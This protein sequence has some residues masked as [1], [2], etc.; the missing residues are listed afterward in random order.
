M[1]FNSFKNCSVVRESAGIRAVPAR[2]AGTARIPVLSPKDFRVMTL[3]VIGHVTIRP[4]VGSFL[5]RW[6]IDIK[7][8]CYTVSDILIVKHVGVMT[9]TV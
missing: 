9:L 3:T 2:R 5:Y 6:H 7:P 8:V 4:A 1:L